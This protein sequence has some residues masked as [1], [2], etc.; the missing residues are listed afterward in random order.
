M[1]ALPRYS[2]GGSL[3]SRPACTSRNGKGPLRKNPAGLH[4]AWLPICNSM[5]TLPG[6]VEPEV[7]FRIVHVPQVGHGST[8]V[9][10]HSE[11][12]VEIT[13]GPKGEGGTT[14]ARIALVNLQESFR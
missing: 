8:P 12:T 11:Q 2:L 5:R 14:P 4:Q 10:A 7:W 9:T 1:A 3:A 6:P 13:F